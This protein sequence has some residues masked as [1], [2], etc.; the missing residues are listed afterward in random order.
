MVLIVA[1]W[2]RRLFFGRMLGGEQEALYECMGTAV[3]S[4]I[5]GLATFHSA[6]NHEVLALSLMLFLGKLAH[7]L[8]KKRME[9]LALR[10]SL[11]APKCSNFAA[12]L[13]LLVLLL[14]TEIWSLAL[15]FDELAINGPSVLLLCQ[16]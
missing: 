2:L 12:P 9:G 14:L 7:A 8:C 4:T 3:L 11:R 10:A 15:C 6:L 1:N 16:F 13:L 5:C